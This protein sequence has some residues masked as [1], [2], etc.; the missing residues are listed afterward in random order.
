LPQPAEGARFD[1]VIASLSLHYFAWDE[2]VRIVGRVREALRAGGVFV[3]R[4]NS[5]DDR[6]FGATGHREIEPNYYVVNGAPKRFFDEAAIDA[7]FSRGWRVRSKIHAITHKY[8]LPKALWEVVLE[9]DTA[10]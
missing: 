4:L 7:L 9:R 1:A 10:P 2:T 5:T 3:C 8:V 6:H